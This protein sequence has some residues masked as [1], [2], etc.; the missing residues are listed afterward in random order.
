[1]KRSNGYQTCLA[2]HRDFHAIAARVL[3]L[4]LAGKKAEAERSMAVGGEYA[5]ASSA[6][7]RAMMEWKE[8][9][10]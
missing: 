4:A 10:Q 6:L 8:K 7:T 5:A 9:T 1:V 3:S 2:L